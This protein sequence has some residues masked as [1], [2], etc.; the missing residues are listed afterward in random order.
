MRGHVRKRGKSWTWRVSV[1]PYPAQRCQDCGKRE[2]LERSPRRSC[3]KC[4]GELFDTNGRRAFA[5]GGFPT[6]RAAES[7]LARFIRRLEAGGDAFPER[8]SLRTYA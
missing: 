3:P 2:W 4:S 1:E 8:M 5:R 6:K 7:D